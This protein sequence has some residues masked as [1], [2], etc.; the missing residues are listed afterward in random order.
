MI[1]LFQK[2]ISKTDSKFWSYFN[3][4]DTRG[5]NL[6][7]KNVFLLLIKIGTIYM[8]SFYVDIILYT[9]SEEVK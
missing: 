6:R 4:D 1:G 9:S 7:R 5:P 8:L 2:D 3:K